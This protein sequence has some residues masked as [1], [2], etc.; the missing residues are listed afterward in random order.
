MMCASF[1]VC[2]IAVAKKRKL[3]E[4]RL[5][6][7]DPEEPVLLHPATAEHFRQ[8]AL[9]LRA[10][11]AAPRTEAV[12]AQ[13]VTQIRELVDTIV[14]GPRRDKGTAPITVY[15]ALA[16]ILAASKAQ[17]PRSGDVGRGERI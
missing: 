4:A 16:D 5:A 11:F 10:L 12:V 15:G 1:S 8:A 14:I 2:R 13:L 3:L 17:L 9:E 6:E 7:G